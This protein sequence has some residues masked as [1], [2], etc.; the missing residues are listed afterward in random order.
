VI[1]R[2]G[3]L[4]QLA[5]HKAAH[6]R[7]NIVVVVGHSDLAW[8]RAGSELDVGGRCLVARTLFATDAGACGV[9]SGPLGVGSSSP[10]GRSDDYEALC[11]DD[12]HQQ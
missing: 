11:V 1:L 5:E 10:R 2:P 12:L 4:T 6:D 7:F 9:R 3:W 8:R